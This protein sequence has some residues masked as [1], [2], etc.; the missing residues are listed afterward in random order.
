MFQDVLVLDGAAT[1]C[2]YGAGSTGRR[3]FELLKKAGQDVRCFLDQSKI[4]P[5][6][7]SGVPVRAPFPNPLRPDA[8]RSPV[9][10]TVFNR[11]ADTVAIARRLARSGYGPIISYPDFH[12]L[13]WKD[14]GGHFWL[15]DPAIVGRQS[16][17][18]EAVDRL[19][20]DARSRTV[21]RSLVALYRSR[22]PQQAP[23]PSWRDEEYVGP[24]VPGWP[25]VKPVRLVDCGA[26]D[27][28]T[29]ERLRVARVPVEAAACFEPDPENFNRLE[30]RL[31]GWPAA[32][33]RGVELWPCGVAERAGR[34]AFESGRGEASR[35]WE[36]AAGSGVACVSLDEALPR[37]APN[38]VKLDVEGAEEQALR[39]AE[40]LVREHRPG[41]AVSVYH[42]PADLWRLPAVIDEWGLGYRLFLRSYGFNAFDTIC[43]AVPGTLSR[44]AR[45]APPRGGRQR[46]R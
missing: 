42:R 46:A 45:R 20:A 5:R 23:R 27:G 14:L 22:N 24:D 19:W 43:Y 4:G 21:F 37:F 11:D 6:T 39:G 44:R 2:L 26:Y 33:R 3:V 40:G 28:D 31:A 25:P 13:H 34:F 35:L 16:K 1:V 7:I 15:G 10:L 17:E 9:V 38:L 18:I 8:R 41:L 32:R 12:A 36:T 29:L 30:K